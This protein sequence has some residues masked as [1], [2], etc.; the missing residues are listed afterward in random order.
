[1]FSMLV[2]TYLF[3]GG[4]GGGLLFIVSLWS[5]LFHRCPDRS[6]EATASF[7]DLKRLCYIIG[8]LL[9]LLAAGCLLMD[10]G[11]PAHFYL[12][13]FKPNSSV[14]SFGTFTLAATLAISSFL[15]LA[16]QLI[17]GMPS[18]AKKVA[19]LLCVGSSF[20]LIAYVGVFL[21]RMSTVPFWDSPL[22][23]ALF[24]LSALSTGVAIIFLVAPFRSGFAWLE[25]HTGSLRVGHGL[26]LAL[27]LALLALL[28]WLA[29]L[30]WT[31][32]RSVELLFGPDL[33]WWFFIGAV[34]LGIVL[35][36]LA[37]LF[38]LLLKKGIPLPLFSLLCL[39]GGFCLRYC[40]VMAGVH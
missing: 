37:E 7:D 39:I 32:M 38:S 16:N 6:S 12:L 3:L 10:L 23:P 15:A 25:E 24:I 26:I 36:L 1:M 9:L 31:T 19:E 29:T 35:P 22:I 28:V 30:D 20:F 5:L 11:R 33:V 40:I 21:Q 17:D 2:I 4:C 14:L 13:F 18:K 34:G 27:E 8:L